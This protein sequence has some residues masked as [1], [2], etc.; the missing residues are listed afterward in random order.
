MTSTEA[1]VYNDINLNHADRAFGQKFSTND[2]VVKVDDVIEMHKFNLFVQAKLNTKTRS[3]DDRCGFISVGDAVVPFVVVDGVKLVPKF[4]LDIDG[5]RS[6][7][8][9]HGVTVS[10]WDLV[11]L[12][13][14][15]LYIG[16]RRDVFLTLPEIPCCLL[17]R[18][19]EFLPAGTTVQETWP[20][21]SPLLSQMSNVEGT[22]PA[23]AIGWYQVPEPM[24]GVVKVENSDSIHNSG[25]NSYGFNN[26]DNSNSFNNN[27]NNSICSSGNNSNSFNYNGSNLSKDRAPPNR[28]LHQRPVHPKAATPPTVT[29]IRSQHLQPKPV[30]GRHQAT[31]S[32]HQ[33]PTSVPV[34][35]TPQSLPS[36]AEVKFPVDKFANMLV[37][38]PEDEKN[39]SYEVIELVVLGKRLFGIRESPTSPNY[40]FMLPEVASKVF[41]TNTLD[42]VVDA[43]TKRRFKL[44][45][46][47]S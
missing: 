12:K 23:A 24:A 42:D 14:A 40:L 10:G 20:D 41:P 44:F 34:P 18:T 3:D 7:V 15:C 35:E 5:D 39:F 46:G 29:G 6:E 11:Y 30:S 32:G 16:L 26:N 4:M 43:L 25:N 8:D 37:K 9:A 22:S 31:T 36:S 1:A 45:E 21:E 28:P 17:Q 19:T 13:F 2:L 33:A 27:C 38:I 47:N